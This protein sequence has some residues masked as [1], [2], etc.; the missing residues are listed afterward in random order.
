MESVNWELAG[1]VIGALSMLVGVPLTVIV[2][3]LRAIREGQRLLQTHFTRRV[4]R[5]E[6]E[7]QRIELCVEEVQK[8][9]TTKEEW[10]RETMLARKQLARLTELLVRLQAEIEGSRGLATQFVR[11]T[12]AIIEL[13][14][15]LGQQLA[16]RSTAGL[17]QDAM[18][19][20]PDA[21]QS[22]RPRGRRSTHTHL[23]ERP[24][25]S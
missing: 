3:Y 14:E 4:E 21:E 2:F 25:P 24:E 9:Y 6:T 12:N 1:T 18:S 5:I 22:Y 23:R 15:R 7:C 13:T 19:A 16:S 8:R 11:A 20:S 10:I 17:S